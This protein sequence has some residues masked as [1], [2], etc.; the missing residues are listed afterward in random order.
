MSAL[1]AVSI[2]TTFTIQTCATFG[3]NWICDLSWIEHK[4]LTQT[5]ARGTDTRDY[6]LFETHSSV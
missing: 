5:R 6:A 1:V 3:L 4:G 2:M